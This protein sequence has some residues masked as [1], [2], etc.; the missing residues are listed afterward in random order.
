MNSIDLRERVRY[1]KKGRSAQRNCEKKTFVRHLIEI[2]SKVRHEA[3]FYFKFFYGSELYIFQE[4]KLL[5]DLSHK[6]A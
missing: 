1:K 6:N 3:I 5:I 4:W 2:L